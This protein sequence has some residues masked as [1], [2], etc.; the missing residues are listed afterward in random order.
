MS[1]YYIREYLKD[2]NGGCYPYWYHPST[3]SPN[4]T[5]RKEPTLNY[6][7]SA[8]RSKVQNKLV[9][10]Q[11][12][13]ECYKTKKRRNKWFVRRYAALVSYLAELEV[14]LKAQTKPTK[15]ER[16]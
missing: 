7:L 5:E 9:K 15:A 12:K 14:L 2:K 3:N 6:E 13:L 1:E 16:A 11:N 10:Y 4:Q 8:L